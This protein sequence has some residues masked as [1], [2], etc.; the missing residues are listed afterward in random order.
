MVDFASRQVCTATTMFGLEEILMSELSALGATDIE[1][2]N[3]AV[4]F[5]ADRRVLYNCNLW[6]R[7]ALRILVPIHKFKAT[8]EEELYNGVKQVAWSTYMEADDTLAVES[9][10]NSPHFNHSQYVALKTKD[11]VVDQFRNRFG[12]RP[13]VD[14]NRPSIRIHVHIYHDQ[15][16][17]S[18]DSSNDSLHRRG[19]RLEQNQAPL[20]EVL[21][22]GMLKLAGWEGTTNFIDPMCGSGT[23]VTEAGLIAKNIA[24]GLFREYFGFMGWKDYDPDL[25]EE[26]K[27]QS[28]AVQREFDYAIV[29]SDIDPEAVHIARANVT[30]AGLD[31]DVKIVRRA[32]EEQEPPKGGGLMVMNP[33]YGERLELDDIGFF[34]KMIGN[35]LKQKYAGYDAWILSSNLAAIKLVGLRPSRKIQLYNG[36]LECR[37]HKFSVFDG[38]MKERHENR[39]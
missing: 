10:V 4:S 21:A 29:G 22:A 19:Y 34:Y 3:R 6:L 1:K 13:N 18:L 25:W 15:C 7:T 37:F 2:A 14:L 38:S 9:A 32:Y 28:L 5:K 36:P 17:L 11:A 23:I 35:I 39:H 24:P 30:R 8:N 27:E 16:T 20:N 12:R 31:E 33:P 26:L